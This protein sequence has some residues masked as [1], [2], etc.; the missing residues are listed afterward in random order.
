MFLRPLLILGMSLS[1]GVALAQTAPRR[2]VG[3]RSMQRT[4]VIRQ[5]QAESVDGE[6]ENALVPAL[7]DDTE[8]RPYEES[9]T[10]PRP[11]E[12]EP[13]GTDD[14]VPS[15]SSPL[16]VAKPPAST[17]KPLVADP[18]PARWGDVEKPRPTPTNPPAID[19]L[20]IRPAEG[21]VQQEWAGFQQSVWNPDET[22]HHGPIFCPRIDLDRPDGLAPIGVIGDH[23]LEAGGQFLISYRYNSIMA[24]GM[25][26]GTGDVG[27]NEVLQNFTYA[28]TN[29]QSQRHMALIEYGVT[30]DLTILGMLPYVNI[31]IDQVTSTGDKIFNRAVDPGDIIFQALYVLW[32]GDRQQV[33]LNLGMQFPLGVQES[34]RFPP[35]PTSP[36]KGYPLQISSGTYDFMPGLTYR[37]QNDDWTWGVQGTGMIRFG[38]NNQDYKFGNRFQLTGWAARKLSDN[39]SLSARLDSN[40]WAN[41]FGAYPQ[42]NQALTPTNRPDYQGGRRIDILFGANFYL[43]G[44]DLPSSVGDYLPS[45]WFS[46]E[47]GV[48]VYQ[49]LMGPQL[50][51]SW[52]IT[53]G[54]NLRF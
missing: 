10:L 3:L 33:H 44:R 28:P 40:I 50:K 6:R 22:Y 31:G 54:W 15:P 52:I 29:M 36:D 45:Q 35:T 49:S 4:P 27:T 39:L 34:D 19:Y 2:P 17:G 13:V 7:A 51:T 21:V 42:L 20:L 12:R 25:R 53:A 46:V 30:D 48:P 5:V 23:T 38:L 47:G 14:V 41:V 16:P 18:V 11:G 1:A 9:E 8:L 26:D 32:R 43:P 37:G 24:D